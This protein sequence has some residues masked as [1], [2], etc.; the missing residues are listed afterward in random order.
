MKPVIQHSIRRATDEA[1]VLWSLA[2]AQFPKKNEVILNVATGQIIEAISQFAMNAR[3]SMESVSKSQ[4]FGLTQ[5]RWAWESKK[6][7][8]LVADF[9]YATNR[10]IHAKSLRV[11]FEELPQNIA[12]IDEGA[13]VIPYVEAE[14]ADRQAAFIDPFAFSHAYLYQIIPFLEKK[15][16]GESNGILH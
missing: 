12:V 15:Y 1:I 10:I 5:P 2:S 3:R 11:G 8:A 4:K 16:Q 7:Q 14:T 13:F 9:R 6:G